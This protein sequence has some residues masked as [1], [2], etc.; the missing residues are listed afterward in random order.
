[1][2]ASCAWLPPTTATSLARTAEAMKQL[3]DRDQVFGFVGNVG[4]PPAVVAAPFSPSNAGCCSSALSLELAYC[5]AIRPTATSSTTAPATRRRPT[6]P[7]ATWLRCASQ[8]GADRGLRPAGWYGDSGYS[9]VEKAV[10]ALRGGDTNFVLRV[11]YTRNTIDVDNAIA[12][13]RLHRTPIKA[14]VMVGTYRA[15]AKFIEKMRGLSRDDFH[16]CLF[17]RQHLA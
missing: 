7:C 6:R 13:R 17:R 9:G 12:T 16:Q 14:V 15:C 10:R 4:T 1:M 8:A 5:G 3:Y 11:G 2:A